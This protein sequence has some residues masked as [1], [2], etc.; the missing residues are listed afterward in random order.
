VF[1]DFEIIAVKSVEAPLG[2]NPHKT[3]VVFGKAVHMVVG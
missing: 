3:I 2:S 1:E